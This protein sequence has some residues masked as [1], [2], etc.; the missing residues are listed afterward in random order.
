MLGDRMVVIIDT[1]T[2][3]DTKCGRYEMVCTVFMN[4]TLRISLSI[5][6]KITG[7]GNSITSA[8]M[9]SSSVFPM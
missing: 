3:V 5:R 2:T 9:F 4:L 6:A 1:T 8:A 7:I